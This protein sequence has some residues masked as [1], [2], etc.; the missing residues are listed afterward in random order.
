MVAYNAIAAT[1]PFPWLKI[2]SRPY[3]PQRYEI[4]A[5]EMLENER[6]TMA[7]AFQLQQHIDR[8]AA[9]AEVNGD[10]HDSRKMKYLDVESR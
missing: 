7:L 6:I 8:A 10:F 9:G 2:A 4:S 1:T 5:E 3:E